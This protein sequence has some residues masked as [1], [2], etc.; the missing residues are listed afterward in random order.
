M[1]EAFKCILLGM[2]E[3]IL[4]MHL[5]KKK[6]NKQQPNKKPQT[7]KV[8]KIILNSILNPAGIS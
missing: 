8:I 2:S 5:V 6:K 4:F 7:F 1:H 3:Q